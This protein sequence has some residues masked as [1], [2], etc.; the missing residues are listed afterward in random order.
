M[1]FIKGYFF[2]TKIAIDAAIDAINDGE[3]IPKTPDSVTKT[4][5]QAIQCVGGYYLPFDQVT[6]KYLSN[7]ID[8]ELPEQISMR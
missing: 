8:I 5:C 7:P 4:Y 1:G 3:G 6:S 2:Q